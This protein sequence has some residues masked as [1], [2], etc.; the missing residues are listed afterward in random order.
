MDI[1]A[2]AIGY[3]EDLTWNNTMPARTGDELDSG[4]RRRRQLFLLPLSFSWH[5][6]GVMHGI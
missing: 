6:H 4:L 5:E 1:H 3:M 2:D